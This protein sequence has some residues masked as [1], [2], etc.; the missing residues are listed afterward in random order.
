MVVTD[1][2]FSPQL[3]HSFSNIDADQQNIDISYQHGGNK[4]LSTASVGPNHHLASCRPPDSKHTVTNDNGTVLRD[5]QRPLSSSSSFCADPSQ[6]QLVP[7]VYIN[8]DGVPTCYEVVQPVSSLSQFD[9]TSSDPNSGLWNCHCFYVFTGGIMFLGDV[10]C[11]S[12]IPSF[13]EST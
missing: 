12:V 1:G 9:N 7:V 10:H 4:Q 6:L 8:A 5:L 13:V 2:D 11:L 3:M